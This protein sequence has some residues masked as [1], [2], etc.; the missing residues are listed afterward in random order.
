MGSQRVRHNWV[1][2]HMHT[3]NRL[4]FVMRVDFI[5]SVSLKRKDW[6]PQKWKEF[7]LQ[8][9]FKYKIATLTLAGISS[10]LAFLAD[11][12]LAHP[13]NHISQ[14]LKLCFSHSLPAL[15]QF[16]WLSLSLYLSIF[17][18][19]SFTA[20]PWWI[21]TPLYLHLYLTLSPGKCWFSPFRIYS[22]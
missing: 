17:Y 22:H 14:F 7:Y 6:G 15:S 18:W 16:H 10:L 2:E 20:E 9:V 21:Y 8:T 4:L 1:T 12:R 3:E 11:F 5:Q 19:F 13:N